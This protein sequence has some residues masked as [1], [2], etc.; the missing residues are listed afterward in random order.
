MASSAALGYSEYTVDMWWTDLNATEIG[1]FQHT[2][3]RAKSRQFSKDSDIIGA[4]D[5]NGERTSLLTYRRALWEEAEGMNKRL[6]IKLFSEAM[7]WR[8]TMDMLLGRSLQLTIGAHGFPV[9]AF[10]V[11]LAGHE[12]LISVERS[13]HKWPLMPEDYSF[14]LIEGKQARFYRLRRDWIAIG[15]DYSLFDEKGGKIGHL[16]GRVLNLGGRWDVRI[17]EDHDNPRLNA[18]L[19]LFCGMLRFRA[20]AERHIRKLVRGIKHGEV[21]AKIETH[22]TDL[23]QNPRRQNS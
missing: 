11:N 10:T 3:Q 17:R 22:E 9:A 19:Q 1:I 21:D 7:N 13:A 23:Y 2:R 14:F 8:G 18:T 20:A 5:V 15:A 6:V 4:V 16:N 12:Q